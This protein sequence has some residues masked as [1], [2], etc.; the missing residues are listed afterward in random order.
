MEVLLGASF[1]Y[2]RIAFGVCF[3][4]VCRRPLHPS[5][6]NNGS[7][8][9]TVSIE[10]IPIEYILQHTVLNWC[11]IRYGFEKQWLRWRD[12]PIF[13][14]RCLASGEL[15]YQAV[16]LSTL[17]KDTASE[18]GRLLNALCSCDHYNE[19]LPH[20]QRKWLLAALLWLYEHQADYT[21]ILAF[22][23]DAV[24]DVENPSEGMDWL[25]ILPPESGYNPLHHTY[26]EN[27]D[28][29]NS[30]WKAYLCSNAGSYLTN[31]DTILKS[32]EGNPP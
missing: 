14:D 8:K 28:R 30:R 15:H 3:S 11:D 13:A 29:L 10:Q 18:A 9:P 12:L 20:S 2:C 5:W 7:S 31:Y 1:L 24:D 16:Q 17:T 6:L 27:I 23:E 21:D 22:A 32:A 4:I 25:R 26:E 19:S